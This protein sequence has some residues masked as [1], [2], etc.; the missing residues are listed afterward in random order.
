MNFQQAK[1]D[2][3]SYKQCITSLQQ[4]QQNKKVTH[5]NCFLPQQIS[6]SFYATVCLSKAVARI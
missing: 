3:D 5:T 6:F 1:K 4:C 2:L